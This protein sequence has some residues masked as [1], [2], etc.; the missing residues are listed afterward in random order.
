MTAL[1]TRYSGEFSSPGGETLPKVTHFEIWNE[2]NLSGF[3][4]P[5]GWD[6]ES[7]TVDELTDARLDTYAAMDRGR[8]RGRQGGRPRGDR[9]RRR[10]RAAQQHQ[11]HRR[12]RRGVDARARGAQDP[13]RRVLA[14]RLPGRAAARGDDGGAELEH[15]R[16]LP[17]RPRRVPPRAGP[18]HHRGR[19]H[20]GAR[21]G[22]ATPRSPRTSRPT[23]STRSTRCRSCAASGSR[24]SSGST[25][26]TTSTG[27]RACCARTGRA[28]RATGGSSAW[29]RTREGR[30]W[31]A[32]RRPRRRRC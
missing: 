11:P 20:D 15:H 2:P 28:S 21:R 27:R 18:L 4:R 16:A 25:S 8:L 29:S 13:A 22:S 5:P 31:A 23:T 9:H 17:E 3:L 26:R 19:L 1:A 24:R 32:R 10:R 30:R 6:D 14:A 7:L 12:R